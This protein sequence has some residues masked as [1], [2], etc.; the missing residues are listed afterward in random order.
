MDNTPARITPSY[1]DVSAAF[2]A[3]GADFCRVRCSTSGVSALDID[4][5]WFADRINPG[6]LQSPVTAMC[7]LPFIKDL[8]TV[9]RNLGGFLFAVAGDQ[10]LSSRLD[11]DIGWRN[12]NVSMLVQ[13]DAKAVPRKLITGAKPTNV[14]HMQTKSRIVVST[15]EAKEE[16][17][18]PD[19]YRVLHSTLKLLKVCDDKPLD[20][21]EINQEDAEELAYRLVVAQHSLKHAERV[22]SIVEWRF[23]NKEGKP[24]IFVIVGTGITVSPGKETGRRLIFSVGSRGSK[25]LLQK[26]SVYEHPVYCVVMFD[27]RS[28]VSVI[29]KTLSFDQFDSET[30]R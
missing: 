3:C 17:V 25:L 14:I 29:G 27:N 12:D 11:S 15:I 4:S 30:G 1:T 22:Y 8:D 20:E 16:R 6:K 24:Y 2:V 28:T 10:L 23:K 21:P 7:Q 13:R 26:E 5:I 9:G 18:P 19:G